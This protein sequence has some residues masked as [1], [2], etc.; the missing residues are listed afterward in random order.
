MSQHELQEVKW[1][2]A[3]KIARGEIRVERS[4][5]TVPKARKRAELSMTKCA[6]Y[7]R[8][9]RAELVKQGLTT[10]GQRRLRRPNGAA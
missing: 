2:I 10:L 1:I 3:R 8:R 7:A 6:V 5:A 9:R 4:H